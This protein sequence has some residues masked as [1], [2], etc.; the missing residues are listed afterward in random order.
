MITEE[1]KMKPQSKTNS[2]KL[3]YASYLAV[4]HDIKIAV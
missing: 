1:T 4:K 3:V 2:K